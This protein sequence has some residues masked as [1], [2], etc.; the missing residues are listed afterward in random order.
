MPPCLATKEI[1][2]LNLHGVIE[3]CTIRDVSTPYLGRFPLPFP[4]SSLSLINNNTPPPTTPPPHHFPTIHLPLPPPC[5]PP[6][7]SHIRFKHNIMLCHTIQHPPCLVIGAVDERSR[8]MRDFAGDDGGEG[9]GYIKEL[10]G[11]VCQ[12]CFMR[13]YAVWAREQ[14]G[15]K[16]G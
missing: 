4:S 10:G 9:V 14:V 7:L 13:T 6:S 8:W 11:G 15:K 1:G 3:S 16:G 2:D 5:S 12:L